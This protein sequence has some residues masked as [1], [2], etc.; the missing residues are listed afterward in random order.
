MCMRAGKQFECEVVSDEDSM[1]NTLEDR[2]RMGAGR[3]GAMYMAY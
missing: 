2:E 3:Y 1:Y